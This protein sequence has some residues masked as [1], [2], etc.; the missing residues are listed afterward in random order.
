VLNFLGLV[1]ALASALVGYV[2]ARQY[3]QNKLRFVDA[4]HRP[5]TAVLAG[6]GAACIAAPVVWLLP[7]VGA[8]TAILF[9][10]GVATGV[11]SGAREI[12]KRLGAG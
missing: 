2:Q 10:A 5:M 1:I 9:G 4:V 12:R 11:L 6:I 3:T 8:G 7:I